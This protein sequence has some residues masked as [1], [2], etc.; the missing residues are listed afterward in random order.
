MFDYV[1]FKEVFGILK[2]GLNI[3]KVYSKIKYWCCFFFSKPYPVLIYGAS[4]V[5]KSEF[6]RSLL[7]KPIAPTDAPRT[8]LYQELT[9]VL[10]DG[11]KIR[12]FDL[13]G[14]AGFKKNR[15]KALGKIAKYKSYGIIYVVSYGYH[16]VP[17]GQNLKMF[18]IAA[19][20]ENDMAV[21][22]TQYQKDNI[23]RELEQAKEWRSTIHLSNRIGWIV[24]VV[25]KA[26]I[27]FEKKDE[28][29]RYYEDE[30]E[31]SKELLGEHS[32]HPR[33]VY[34]YCSIISPFCKRPMKLTF[35]ERKKIGFHMHLRA[36]L[37]NMIKDEKKR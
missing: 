18:K 7:E 17:E 11:H 4:G 19:G 33:L 15:E 8:V 24:T 32:T 35:G 23:K 1:A 36:D 34:P 13:P 2:T 14:H 20:S 3:V 25:N 6:C 37:L 22:D 26:D 29:M 9:L 30:E 5:G 16:E 28:V 12:L 27:W 31:Y 10:E 21:I